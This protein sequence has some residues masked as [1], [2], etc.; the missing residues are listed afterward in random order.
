MTSE[1]ILGIQELDILVYS[2]KEIQAI[3]HELIRYAGSKAENI[4]ANTVNC[5]LMDF[6]E[7]R[8]PVIEVIKRIRLAKMKEKYGV[9]DFAAF[10]NVKLQDYSDFYKHVSKSSLVLTGK[11]ALPSELL[12]EKYGFTKGKSYE[13]KENSGDEILVTNDIG[14]TGFYPQSYFTLTTKPAK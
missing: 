5:W 10:M 7:L 8:M 2:P 1:K 14:V 12:V 4:Q 6:Q 13:I 11:V 9:T 3:K